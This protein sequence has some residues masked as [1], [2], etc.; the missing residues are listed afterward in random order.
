[1][2]G[3]FLGCF[4]P[5]RNI[6]SIVTVILFYIISTD[7]S[8]AGVA[9]PLRCDHGSAKNNVWPTLNEMVFYWMSSSMTL[10]NTYQPFAVSL[11][12]FRLST[13]PLMMKQG[14]STNGIT[15]SPYFL[16][17]T[18]LFELSYE[19]SDEETG[20]PVPTVDPQAL[21][22]PAERRNNTSGVPRL[23]S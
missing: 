16:E 10:P 15:L 13:D 14:Y 3:G 4:H 21:R 1:M 18:R 17:D 6:R 22:P 5:V 19:V 23:L 12:P 20:T 2:T 7:W 8:T 11:Y 9:R